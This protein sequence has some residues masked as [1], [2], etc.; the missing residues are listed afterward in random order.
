MAI[1]EEGVGTTIEMEDQIG[2][3]MVEIV[4]V[5]TKRCSALCILCTKNCGSERDLNTSGIAG[6]FLNWRL[7]GRF[8]YSGQ[9]PFFSF[10]INLLLHRGVSF[11]GLGLI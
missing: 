7:R 3:S 10:L 8:I 4:P 1:V 5:H 9:Y 2:I 11:L 6:L